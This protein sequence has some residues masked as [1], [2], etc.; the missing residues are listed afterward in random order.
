MLQSR[1]LRRIFGPKRDEVTGGWRKL[2]NED[3]S[4]L[5]CTPSIIRMMKSR[6]IWAGHIARIWQKRNAYRILVE[7]PEG[8]RQED[9]DG[10]K[11]IIFK[12]S[13]QHSLE[14]DVLLPC[15]QELASG[16][17]PERDDSSTHPPNLLI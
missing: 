17:Y 1:V 10:V 7:K 8:K 15:S 9:L 13:S 4:N 2:R 6:K 12:W 14:R 16:P 11:M 5:Y 3:F